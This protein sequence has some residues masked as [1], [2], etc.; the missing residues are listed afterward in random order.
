[1]TIVIE[2]TFNEFYEEYKKKKFGFTFGYDVVKDKIWCCS[3]CSNRIFV[4]DMIFY[5]FKDPDVVWTQH[6]CTE[7]C[8][9]SALITF[10]NNGITT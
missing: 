7:R 3:A 9:D 4:D 1:M 5:I 2:A 10:K 8:K 6:F